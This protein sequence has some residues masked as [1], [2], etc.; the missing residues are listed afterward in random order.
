VATIRSRA[1]MVHEA[2]AQSF[3]DFFLFLFPP[4]DHSHPARRGQ[5]HH[6]QRHG[7]ESRIERNT[8]GLRESQKRNRWNAFHCLFDSLCDRI[9]PVL[10]R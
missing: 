8:F 4:P 10:I 7:S 3:D 1:S 2:G 5:N 6:H 9:R